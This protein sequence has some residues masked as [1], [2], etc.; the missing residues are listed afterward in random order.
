MD[1]L[2]NTGIPNK[3]NQLN[4]NYFYYKQLDFFYYCYEGSEQY[5]KTMNLKQICP[6]LSLV[7]MQ[8]S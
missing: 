6:K 1:D 2:P 8:N 7:F 5:C 3:L 4:R